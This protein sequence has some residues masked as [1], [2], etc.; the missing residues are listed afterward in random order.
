MKILKTSDTHYGHSNNTHKIHQKFLDNIKK[1]ITFNDVRLIIHAGDWSSSHQDQF[2]RTLNMWR[3]TLGDIPIVTSRGNHEL[4]DQRK[5]KYD[6]LTGEMSYR[7]QLP[8]EVMDELHKE[9][10]KEYNIHHL[11]S[12]GVFEI[13]DI[14]VFGFDGW[15]YRFDAPTNDGG[16]IVPYVG[17][18]TSLIYHSHRAYK[19][20]DKILAEDM[21]KYRKTICVTHFPPFCKEPQWQAYNANP[22]FLEPIKEKFDVLCVGHSHRYRNDIEDGTHIINAGSGYDRPQYVVF[23][24]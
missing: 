10:F 8:W 17:G 3:T 19:A 24:V 11:E 6:R 16:M 14:G 15:Y 12:Q 18:D 13:D 23:E 1:E 21:D 5:K 4:W 20:L 22:S 9:W 7:R 2:E